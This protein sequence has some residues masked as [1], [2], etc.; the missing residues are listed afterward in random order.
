M[1][2]L[3]AVILFLKKF[4]LFE[5]SIQYKIISKSYAMAIDSVFTVRKHHHTPKAKYY[6]EEDIILISLLKDC[7]TSYD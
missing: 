1:K 7:I 6:K 2:I 4:W 5:F 3:M